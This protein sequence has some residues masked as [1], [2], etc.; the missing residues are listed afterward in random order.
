MS[1]PSLRLIRIFLSSPGDVGDERA[2][3]AKI[4]DDLAADPLLRDLIV[5][6]SVAWDSLSSRTPMLATLT[7]QEAINRRLPKPSECDIVIVLLW[8]RMG[9]PLPFPDY[10]KP[11]GTPYYSGTEW[12]YLDAV[13][14]A[15]NHPHGLPLVVVYR[16][17]EELVIKL[18]DPSRNEK[19]EQWERVQTFFTQFTDKSGAIRGGY[20]TYDTPDDFRKLFEHDIRELI[21]TVLR[22]PTDAPPTETPPPVEETLW[23]GSPFPGL[24]AFTAADAPI[25]FGRGRETDALIQQVSASRFVAVVGASGSGKSSLVGAGLIPRLKDNAISGENLGSKDWH[26]VSFKPGEKEGD[27]FRALADALVK[28]FP[29]LID[30]PLEAARIKAEFV[31]AL[32]ADPA[33]LADTCAAALRNDPAWAEI[34]LFVDQFEELF[35]VVDETLRAPFVELLNSIA[36]A[37]RLRTVVTMRADFFHRCVEWPELNTLINQNTYTLSRPGQIALMEMIT[38]PAERAG[39]QWQDDYLPE[40]ILQ[41]TGDEPGALALLAYTLDELYNAC[42]DVLTHVAYETL[43]GVQGAIG[44]RAEHIFENLDPTVQTT[45]P[46]VFRELVEVD[47]RGTA[48]RHRA[49][50][51]RFADDDPA[52]D[53]LDQFTDARLLTASTVDGESVIEVAHEALFRHWERLA[54]WIELAQDDLRLRRRMVRDA[55]EWNR[56]DRPDHMLPNAEELAEF[57]AAL[58]RLGVRLADLVVETFCEPEADRLLRE[59]DNIKT[60]HARRSA[61][62]ERLCAIGDPRPGVGLREDGL[63]D[64][65]WC[66]VLGGKIE[67]ERQTFTVQPFY[68]AKYQITLVQFQAFLDD[69]DGWDQDE[70]WQGLGQKQQDRY[71]QRARFANYPRETVSWYQAV[72]F[73]RWLTTKLPPDAWPDTSALNIPS[74]PRDGLG[75]LLDRAQDTPD[76]AIRLPA[77]WEWQHAATDGKPGN[78]YPWG[79]DWENGR[80]CNTKESG[81]SRTTAVGM[82]PH[83]ITACGALDMSGNVYDW[84]L[85]EYGSVKTISFDN[86]NSPRAL[87]GGSWDMSEFRAHC[88]YRY[89]N[90]PNYRNNDVGFRVVCGRPP[91]L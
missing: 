19:I 29:A 6:R 51:N 72:A 86:T 43:G 67:I 47:E 68:I 48:T 31:A 3:A 1:T 22:A 17:T 84:C 57:Q 23:P 52:C 41:D 91:S 7:P 49:P 20:N 55:Y 81:L 8:S 56:R 9:T 80:R 62:G 11:D 73:T 66:E 37:D 28:E 25:F 12:E 85:N 35:T 58:D 50:L 26:I 61:V 78:T 33:S 65:V 60:P 90:S 71:E 14:G 36:H 24:R 18:S 88:V 59:L 74:A 64:I 4:I 32:K 83:G 2:L 16:R 75:H 53:L 77:E 42:D 79:P 89:D 30:R 39:L 63:P 21:D 5:V 45:L 87:R 76:W 27:P 15:Q 10:Q 38:R 34:L 13:S 70:W 44:T 54:E 69:P 46:R 82:Y 40:R